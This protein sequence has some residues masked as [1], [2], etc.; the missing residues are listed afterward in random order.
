MTRVY[1][2]EGTADQEWALPRDEAV[3]FQDLLERGAPANW[4]P[5][6]MYLLHEDEE[7]SPLASSDIPWNSAATPVLKERAARLIEPM[8]G[9]AGVLLPLSCTECALWLL[10]VT[11]LAD[12]LDEAASE[13]VRFPSSGRVMKIR[14]HVF[15]ETV[16]R[17]LG[18]FKLAQMPRGSVFFTDRVAD[19]I[20]AAG[21]ERVALRKVWPA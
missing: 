9:D 7:G 18:I 21:L 8:L 3:I 10:H 11:K 12:A 5:V 13:L 19:A 4:D 14:R 17:E 1:Q 6:E 15:K 16:V 2:L 20:G